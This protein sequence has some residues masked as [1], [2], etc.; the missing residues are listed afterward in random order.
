MSEKHWEHGLLTMKLELSDQ[1]S[2]DLIKL[3]SV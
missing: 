3:K 1:L 2:E